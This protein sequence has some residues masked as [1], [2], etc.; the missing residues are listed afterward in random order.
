VTS[1]QYLKSSVSFRC[2]TTR[3]IASFATTTVICPANSLAETTASG[4]AA[5]IERTQ[6]WPEASDASG[7]DFFSS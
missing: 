1:T 4:T 2:R 5:R 7:R 6:G 3:A